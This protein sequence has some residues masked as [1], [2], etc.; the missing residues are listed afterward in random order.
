MRFLILS[1]LDVGVLEV[2]RGGTTYYYALS[3]FKL[4]LK[5]FKKL[6]TNSAGWT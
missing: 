3:N 5:K 6:P 2:M 4:N 1:L